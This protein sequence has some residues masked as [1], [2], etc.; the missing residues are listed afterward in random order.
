MMRLP[1]QNK[2]VVCLLV[3]FNQSAS[4]FGLFRYSDRDTAIGVSWNDVF[5][6]TSAAGH[7]W[8]VCV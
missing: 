4:I 8:S 1:T 2:A 3:M 6:R 5:Y 7:M